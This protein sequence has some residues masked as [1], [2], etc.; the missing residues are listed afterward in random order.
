M[1]AISVKI[2][3]GFIAFAG[4]SLLT[5][6]WS[7]LARMGWDLPVPNI[8]FVSLH[9]PL[10][11]IGFLGT[12][13]GLERAAAVNQWWIYG[14]PLFSLLSIA[15]LMIDAPLAVITLPAILAAVLQTVFFA[16]LYRR[17][18]AEHFVVLT[19]SSVALCIGNVIW[20]AEAP[21]SQVVPWW[22]GFLVLMI[23]GERLELTRI[24]RP[25]LSVRVLFRVCVTIVMVGL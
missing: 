10:M 3:F 17:Q 5:A 21:L 4:V 14:I 11:A 25:P 2:R 8:E 20:F 13:I 12:L 19:L 6:L 18:P 22:A 24:R 7:G 1:P 9:G 15:A 23:A 16:S